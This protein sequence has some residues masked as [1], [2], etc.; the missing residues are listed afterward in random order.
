MFS[1]SQAV[2]FLLCFNCQPAGS[3]GMVHIAGWFCR[4]LKKDNFL[5]SELQTGGAPFMLT[6][7]PTKYCWPVTKSKT[8]RA[9]RSRTGL[10][11]STV[12]P[13]VE[14][15]AKYLPSGETAE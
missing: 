5:P 15:K 1:L 2:F 8:N 3:H 11:S 10:V 13:L 9:A 4:K 14:T 6:P 7:C 12:T